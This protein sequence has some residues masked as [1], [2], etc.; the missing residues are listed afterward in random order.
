MPISNCDAM[1]YPVRMEDYTPWIAAAFALPA[2]VVL[3]AG[4][5]WLAALGVGLL[6]APIAAVILGLLHGLW[7]R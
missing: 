1:C 2:L 5:S 7:G 3:L 4:G 6:A